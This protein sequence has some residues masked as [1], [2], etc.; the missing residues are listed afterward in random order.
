M[1]GQDR[2]PS[3]SVVDCLPAGADRFTR[4]YEEIRLWGRSLFCVGRLVLRWRHPGT[5][6]TIR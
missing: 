6:S 1:V 4:N 3:R 5:R 2:R